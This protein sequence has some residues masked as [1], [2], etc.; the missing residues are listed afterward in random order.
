MFEAVLRM[1]VANFEMK[2]Q[3]LKTTFGS[4]MTLSNRGP[5]PAPQ[6]C[7]FSQGAAALINNS[8]IL[9]AAAGILGVEAYHAGSVRLQ[10]IQNSDVLVKE[11]GVKVNVIVGVRLQSHIY[12]A[13]L[14]TN[15]FASIKYMTVCRIQSVFESISLQ[16]FVKCFP[17]V[18]KAECQSPIPN[19][20]H[21]VGRP[22]LHSA[23][24]S[25][26]PLMTLVSW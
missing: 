16:M 26:A 12:E 9:T 8:D 3:F 21:R 22:S 23:P 20:T 15:V 19:L 10:L 18:H 6:E 5:L 1:K 24:S 17:S 2:V 4:V 25:L 11:Y 14:A 7:M 13:T